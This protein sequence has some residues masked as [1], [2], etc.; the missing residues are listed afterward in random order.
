MRFFS[1]PVFVLLALLLGPQLAPAQTGASTSGLVR[2]A[3]T[4]RPLAY[5][6]V[7]LA[8]TTYGTTT[9]STGHF[10]LDGVPAGQYEFTVSHVGYEL[11]KQVLD[12]PAAAPLTLALRPVAVSL[13]EVTVRPT[14]NRPADFQRFVRQFLGNSTLAQQCRIENPQ[15]VVVSYDKAA[16]ELTALAP[17]NLQVINQALGYRIIYHD[18]SFKIDYRANRVVFVAAPLFE[19]LPS[20]SPKQQRHWEEN[21]RRAYAGSLPHFLRSV[22]ENRLVQEGFLVRRL[23]LAPS[24]E[25]LQQQLTQASDSLVA[26]FAAGPG[27]TAR[28]YKQPVSAA[29][30][31]RVQ[32]N[33]PRTL[34]RFADALQVTY[35]NEQPDPVYTA[36]T[37]LAAGRAQVDVSASRVAGSRS[38][39][40]LGQAA[41]RP[42]ALEVSELRLL[43]PEALILPTG[44]LRNPLSVQVDGYWA[45]EKVGEALPLDYAPGLTNQP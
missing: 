19:A 32:A 4:Q 20:A 25:Q 39:A 12:L 21:R 42:A 8:N 11:Y 41:A 23:V 30:I 18:F 45:F 43:G 44:N 38:S 16:N 14:K 40:P 9:D 7:F 2:D 24:S 33:P 26:V 34:L 28:V 1:L 29:Q 17:R 27:V 35:Q 22:R 10:V 37:S 31:C 36:Y 13:E 3:R 5:A 6:S 15:Q